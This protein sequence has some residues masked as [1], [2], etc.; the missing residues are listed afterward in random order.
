MR[1]LLNQ[2]IN[3]KQLVEIHFYSS[4]SNCFSCGIIVALDNDF[5]AFLSFDPYGR[6]DGFDIRKLSDLCR[7]TTDSKYLKSLELLIEE[8]P[9]AFLEINGE[10]IINN[11]INNSLK[12]KRIISLQTDDSDALMMGYVSLINGLDIK[13]HV[14]DEYGYDDGDCIFNINSISSISYDSLDERK[15]EKLIKLK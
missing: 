7:I 9:P 1:K 13:L 4:S 5:F 12:S 8:D 14:V 6:Y 15:V 3:T 10:S 2:L 11:C